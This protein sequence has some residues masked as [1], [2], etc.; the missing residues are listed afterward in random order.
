MARLRQSIGRMRYLVLYQTQRRTSD[1]AGGFT[2]NWQ[3]LE[4]VDCN[5]E[6]L[7]L[8]KQLRFQSL[9]VDVTDVLTHRTVEK[10]VSGKCRALLIT[11]TP[12]EPVVYDVITVE[13]IG[14]REEFQKVML[15]RNTGKQ[16]PPTATAG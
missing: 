8:G 13:D 6:T 16:G 9:Q 2:V 4:E 3:D 10:L 11:D 15:R 1:G 7:S 5:L 14:N 12:S